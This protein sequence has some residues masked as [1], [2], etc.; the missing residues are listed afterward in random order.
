MNLHFHLHYKTV[1]GE[2]IGIEYFYDHTDEKDKSILTFQT[3]DGENWTG[4]IHISKIIKVHYRYILLKDGNVAITEW[5]TYRNITPQKGVNTLIEDKWRPRANENNA[6]L[7]TAFTDSI[8]RRSGN[9]ITKKSS[10]TSTKNSISFR[11]TSATI[12]P[13]LSFGIIGNTK[14]LG[15][16]EKPLMMDESEFSEWKIDIPIDDDNIQLSYKYV[17]LDTADQTIKVWEEG[18]NRV[19][20]FALSADQKHHIVIADD[21][22]RYKDAHWRGAGVAI[23]VFSLRSHQGFGIGEFADLKLLTDWTAELGMNIIQ[24]LP[25]NDTIANKNWV[26]SYPYA[27]ISVFALHPLYIHLPSI[28]TFKDKKI[29]KDFDAECKALNALDKVDFEKVLEAKFRYLRILF[30]QEYASFKQSKEY[31]D[32]YNSNTTWLN[33][34]AVFCHLRD[35]NKTCNFNL[36]PEYAQYTED[37]LDTLCNT[38]Y[39]DFYEIE[40]YYFIQ[41]HADK[42]LLEAKEYA[43][44]KSVV[45]KG[46]LPIGIYRH[47]CDAWVAPSLY[48]M[49]EQA[50]APPDD[51]A[52]LGQN[53]GFPTYNW[54]VMA[55]DGFN[56]WRQRMQ[57]LNRYFDALRIDHILGFFRIWSIPTHQV[58]GTMG[59]FNP[60]LPVSRD[61]LNG[62]GIT[63]D[64]TRYTLPYITQD[65]LKQLFGKDVEDIFEIFFSIS[66]DGKIVFKSSFDDQQK[67]SVFISQNTQYS[68]Y[69]KSLLRLM[70][71]VL[72]LVE[73]NTDGHYFNPRITLSTTYSYSQ[74]DNYTK[75]R[76]NTLYNDYYF[77]RHDEYWKQQALWKL[78]AILDASNM[79]ICGEDLGMI[80]QSVPGVM[81]EM[82]IIS[83]EI[84]RMPKGNAK[85]GEVR[86]YPY[87]SVCSPSCHDMSTIRG[88]WQ[89]DHEMA[90]DYFYNYLHWYGL[91]P[92]D[93]SPDIVH[94]IV[95][96]HLASPSMMAIFPIQDLIGM[97]ATLRNQTAE[98]EQINEPSNPKHYWRFRFHIA[99]NDLLDAKEL[100]T[101]IKEMVKKNGR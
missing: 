74:L 29:Q 69:E 15:E 90:K 27:A 51:Y 30:D 20:H 63:G 93:C 86:S 82:N 81:R 9:T 52:V 80:P 34:Y 66:K 95:N 89:G 85:F 28:A 79:L 4:Q 23:P 5:G 71:E 88:W 64:L 31:Q 22:F 33:Q 21:Q 24:V 83:L 77:K 13:H 54:A 10:K 35:K 78:P 75:A 58:E 99:L 65:I 96:D 39:K 97:D 8:F 18:E 91:T 38:S 17:V 101:K 25:V 12:Q 55:K 16:W 100:N 84:Q 60:R 1:Y 41:F 68:K 36:W 48:N 2:Q 19:C 87:F 46:D 72:L 70:T 45:L 43:R 53:W 94:A 67:I 6:F 76:F 37:V 42:Q 56:W 11:L 50:G 3:Y 44:T 98:A 14:A 40:F 26:D 49:D 61:E 92:M 7:S 59:M 47:S 62:Y 57:Q 73:P 32:F